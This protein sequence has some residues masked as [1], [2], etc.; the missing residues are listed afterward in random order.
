MSIDQ[1]SAPAPAHPSSRTGAGRGPMAHSAKSVA[2]TPGQV[3]SFEQ[4]LGALNLGSDG[5]G[6]ADSALVVP[7]Q[8][9]SGS[10]GDMNEVP[11][12]VAIPMTPPLPMPLPPSSAAV[13]PGRPSGA[14]D[15]FGRDKVSA[16]ASAAPARTPHPITSLAGSSDVSTG[17][18]LP[19]GL[20]GPVSV[21]M[22]ARH[23]GNLGT[24]RSALSASGLA[25]PVAP[26]AEEG[27]PSQAGRF[28][29]KE[30]SPQPALERVVLAAA[31]G[32]EQ[33]SSQGFRPVREHERRESAVVGGGY[34]VPGQKSGL[35]TPPAGLTSYA[36][37]AP[38]AAVA[39]DAVAEKLFYWV[40][41]GVQNAEL[42]VDAFGGGSVDVTVSVQGNQAMVEFRSD[43]PEARRLLNDAMPQLRAM[44][45]E[46]GLMLSGGFV[47]TSGRE[48]AE[49]SPRRHPDQRQGVVSLQLAS[50]DPGRSA[51]SIAAA[52]AGGR[53][54]VYV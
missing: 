46:E 20:D 16:G 31:S 38:D 14:A 35:A 5:S 9:P 13:A 26:A 2:G 23:A 24:P 10:P 39:A 25:S 30:F 6:E 18:G 49:A 42:Q 48:G 45:G 53:L 12:T 34:A 41:G 52:G 51:A 19:A 27:A 44:L 36:L 43:Q 32:V 21:G 50:N 33:A 15:P 22:N 37:T 1:A 11:S 29:L 4:L 54:D 8:A 3:S 17:A 47:G 7:A 40:T 28:D